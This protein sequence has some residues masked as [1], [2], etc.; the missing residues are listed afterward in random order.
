MQQGNTIKQ[1]EEMQVDNVQLVVPKQ[2]I[3]AYP[4]QFRGGIWPLKKFIAYAREKAIA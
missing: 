1:L 2:Y 4:P 3:K